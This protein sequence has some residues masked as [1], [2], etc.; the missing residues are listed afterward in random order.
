VG[1]EVAGGHVRATQVTPILRPPRPEVGPSSSPFGAQPFC[2]QAFEETEGC[3]LSPVIGRSPGSLVGRGLGARLEARLGGGGAVASAVRDAPVGASEGTSGSIPR[4]DARPLLA[5]TELTPTAPRNERAL[6]R[7]SAGPA[8]DG[9][10]VEGHSSGLL[11]RRDL[12]GKEARPA[13]GRA[14][15]AA[16]IAEQLK[17]SLPPGQGVPRRLEKGAALIAEGYSDS[18]IQAFSGQQRNFIEFVNSMDTSG[19]RPGSMRW[20]HGLLT[21]LRVPTSRAIQWSSM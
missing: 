20:L 15:R 21:A 12:D 10:T 16:S 3:R 2:R 5:E 7:P 4:T 19:R 13:D 1:V 9:K 6:M 11:P 8:R 17:N 18:R 14:K